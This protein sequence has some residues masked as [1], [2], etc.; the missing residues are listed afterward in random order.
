MVN[1]RYLTKHLFFKLV[2]AFYHYS[3]S[4]RLKFVSS[5]LTQLNMST[6]NPN[7]HFPNFSHFPMI[8]LWFSYDFPMVSHGFS[9]GK[10]SKPAPKCLAWDGPPAL[11]KPAPVLKVPAARP[12]PGIW[13]TRRR[14]LGGFWRWGMW[15][16]M[17]L[18]ILKRTHTIYI[19]NNNNDNN[20]F[21]YIYIYCVY[22]YMCKTKGRYLLQINNIYIYVCVFEK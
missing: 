13:D 20:N 9:Y 1:L 14:S 7:R 8:F 15:C 2:S 17:I 19:Y 16:G 5:R 18:W 12:R 11:L 3:K 22:I 10:S 21:K 4:K 6:S